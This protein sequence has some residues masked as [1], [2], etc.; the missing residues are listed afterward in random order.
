M[1][2]SHASSAN[3]QGVTDH[4]EKDVEREAI[5]RVREEEQRSLRSRM[6]VG[7]VLPR[8]PSREV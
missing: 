8:Y 2:T 7:F 3:T 6:T 1:R 5:N 4:D